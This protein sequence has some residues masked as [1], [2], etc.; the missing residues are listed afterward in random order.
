MIIILPFSQ[1]LFFSVL[2]ERVPAEQKVSINPG[3]ITQK[4]K[5]DL[6]ENSEI[7][8]STVSLKNLKPNNFIF[9]DY[10]SYIKKKIITRSGIRNLR[11]V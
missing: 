4:E 6:R 9:K 8:N 10:N 7:T 5:Q 11:Q 3:H 1:F 2:F